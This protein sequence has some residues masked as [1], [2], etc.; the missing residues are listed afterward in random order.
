ME[1]PKDTLELSLDEVIDRMYNLQVQ[2]LDVAAAK[3]K[4]AQKVQARAHNAKHARNA[5]EA[6][7][8]AWRMNLLW[9]TELNALRKGPK[10]VGPYEMVEREVVAIA[11]MP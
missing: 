8:K 5:F 11:T 10:W 9:R 1:S 3:I 4:Q 2:I 7:E 6:G